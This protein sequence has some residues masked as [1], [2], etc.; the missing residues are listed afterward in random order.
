MFILHSY[1]DINL[2]LACTEACFDHIIPCDPKTTSQHFNVLGRQELLRNSC[3]IKFLVISIKLALILG[4]ENLPRSA[5]SLSSLK[6]L[7]DCFVSKNFISH[8]Y[9]QTLI[10][11]DS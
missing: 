6:S 11:H 2:Y 7:Q 1:V 10:L 3:S 5:T 4:F 8:L 9:L